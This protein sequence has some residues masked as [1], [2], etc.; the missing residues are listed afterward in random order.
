[1]EPRA[2]GKLYGFDARAFDLYLRGFAFDNCEVSRQAQAAAHLGAVKVAVGL[3]ARRLHGRAAAAIEQ[4]ELYAGRIDDF[5]HDAPERVDFAHEVAFG[6]P[7]DCGVAA[8]LPYG[9]RVNGDERGLCP[10]AR[11]DICGLAPGVPGPYHYNVK[12]ALRFHSH[13]SIK[14]TPAS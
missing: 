14:D 7:A 3:G 1:V 13:S 8:H 10:Y 5:A 11:G 4:P 9:V 12:L 2:A 6:Y